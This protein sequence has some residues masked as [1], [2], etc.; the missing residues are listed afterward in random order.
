MLVEA[1]ASSVVD[2]GCGE[3]AL[4]KTVLVDSALPAV[5]HAVGID[6]SASALTRGCKAVS[7]ALLQ[8]ADTGTLPG[9]AEP[10][11]WLYSVRCLSM[12]ARL[13]RGT[14]LQLTYPA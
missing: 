13:G 6:I 14:L 8:R 12:G 3:C 9:T 10:S 7:A 1:G 2:V 4:L 11:V 5:T